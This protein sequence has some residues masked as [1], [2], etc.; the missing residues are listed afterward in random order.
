MPAVKS[1][2]KAVFVDLAGGILYAPIFWYTRGAFDA[3]K[4]C[5]R[6]IKRKWHV[7]GLGVWVKNIFV[8]MYAQRDLAGTLISFFMRLVQIFA[9]TILMLVWTCLVLLLFLSYLI[10][11]I[12]VVV[13]LLSQLFGN[14]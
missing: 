11:P 5:G 8:P 9:R 6:M 10:V 12:F 1:A 2:G 4:Y 14:L 13:Q 7:F 3:A